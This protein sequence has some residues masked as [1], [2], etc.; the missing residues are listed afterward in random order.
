MADHPLQFIAGEMIKRALSHG[1]ARIRRSVPGRERVDGRLLLQHV[2]LRHRHARGDR[3]LLDD[4]PQSL[5]CRIAGI[6]LDAH[7]A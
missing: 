1:D 6:A 4:V 7:A 2:D 3:H 5:A